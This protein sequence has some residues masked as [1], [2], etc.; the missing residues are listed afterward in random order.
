MGRLYLAA[1]NLLSLAAIVALAWRATQE[2][3]GNRAACGMAALG[4]LAIGAAN[5]AMTQGQN[6]LVINGALALA[7]GTSRKATTGVWGADAATCPS[8]LV[9]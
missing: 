7:L 3:G 2:S 4:V 5:D 1:L 8:W 6:S 9:A